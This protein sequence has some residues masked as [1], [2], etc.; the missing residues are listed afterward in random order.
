MYISI[1][2]LI[3]NFITVKFEKNKKFYLII[4]DYQHFMFLTFKFIYFEFLNSDFII[5][6]YKSFKFVFLIE[7]LEIFKIFTIVFNKSIQ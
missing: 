5:F 4:L 3:A 7:K 2:V 6:F 1:K